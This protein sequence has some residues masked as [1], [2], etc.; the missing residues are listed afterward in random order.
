MP[1]PNTWC[2]LRSAMSRFIHHSSDDGVGLL[3][4]DVDR[5][6]VVLGVD[7]RRQ[8]QLLRIGAREAGV[9]IGAPLHRRAHA[10]AVAEVDVVAHA[11]L[12]AVVEDRRAGQREQQRVHQL[13]LAP[14]FEQR[15]QPA[16]DAE[17]DARVA[18]RGVD[19]VHVVA[20]LVGDHLERQLVVVAQERRPLAARRDRRRLR[21]GCRRSGSDPRAATAMNIRGISGKWKFMWHSSPSPKYAAASSGHWLASAS[22]M[23]FVEAARRCARAAASGTRA[24]R[25]GSRSS[26]PRAR[27]GTAPRRA[28]RRRRPCSS[29]KSITLNS[30]SWTA[31]LSKLRS[32]WCA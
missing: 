29:Q 18:V 21:A 25:A 13:D 15:R 23:R 10:V 27:R 1:R 4:L 5:L 32:G 31:G 22:S 30:A 6:V 9:A 7:D 14:P 8:V 17:V 2:S 28:A 16:A 19:A 11:D 12:V 24:S 20:I 3:R 26:C